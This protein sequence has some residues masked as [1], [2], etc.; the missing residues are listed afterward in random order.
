MGGM[1]VSFSQL[2][3]PLLLYLGLLG[4]LGGCASPSPQLLAMRAIPQM[5][6]PSAGQELQNL[7]M[8]RASQTSVINYKDY[9]V[10]PEDLLTVIIYGHDN[11]NREV[12]VNGQ[13]EIT[14]PLV[15]VVKVAGLTPQRD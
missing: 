12:R 13:G 7:L 1:A 6:S 2:L 11:L 14:L 5:Q 4:I 10:G 3:I 15:G 9:N 8:A